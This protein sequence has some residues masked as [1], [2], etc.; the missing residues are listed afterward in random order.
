MRQGKLIMALMARKDTT[1]TTYDVVKAV[2]TPDRTRTWGVVGHGDFVDLL[3][4]A[5]HANDYDIVK[6]EYSLSRDGGKMFGVFTLDVG[7]PE[8]ARMIGFRNSIN[9]T[10]AAGI[11]AGRRVFVCDNLAFSGE[12]I[13]Y[14]KHVGRLT[15]AVLKDAA[16]T[17]IGTV[18]NKMEAFEGW[19][20]ALHTKKLTKTDAQVLTFRAIENNIL[21]AGN[22]SKFHEL[23]FEKENDQNN[24]YYDDNLYGFHGAMTQIWGNNSLIST[25]PRHGGLV[26]LI[27]NAVIDLDSNGEIRDV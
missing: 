2:G 18:A 5:V 3:T 1:R 15:V 4:D 13:D 24:A 26:K 7:D 23:F 6:Q 10:M 19:H 11:T 17:A 21:P 12:F 20:K 25:G 14:Y 27:D 9:K 22:F 16:H 8:G